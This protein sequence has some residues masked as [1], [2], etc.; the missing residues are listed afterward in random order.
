M[1][2]RKGDV[3]P[4]DV[5]VEQVTRFFVSG[6]VAVPKELTPKH[7]S[8]LANEDRFNFEK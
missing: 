8:K 7:I 1:L 3:V 2:F 6:A 5:T 4:L